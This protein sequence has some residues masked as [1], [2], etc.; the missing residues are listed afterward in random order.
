M[1]Y[2][3]NSVAFMWLT[4]YHGLVLNVKS[5]IRLIT[6]VLTCRTGWVVVPLFKIQCREER[7]GLGLLSSDWSYGG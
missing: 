7:A 6:T 4:E 1:R 5:E 3:G 2:E